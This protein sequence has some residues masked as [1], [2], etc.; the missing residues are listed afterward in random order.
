MPMKEV[1]VGDL[2]YRIRVIPHE[3]GWIASAER[4]DSDVRFGV[5]CTGA[6]ES[7]A[8]DRLLSWLDWQHEHSTA[9]A[10]LQQAERAY[11]RT[12][13]GAAFAAPGE[14]PSV[15]ELQSESLEALEAARVRLDEVRAR[16]PEH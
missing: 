5:E 15:F 13:A 2:A 10:A 6:T 1:S 11:H 3:A 8:T 12:L 4:A 14:E 7:E 9:L 16:K